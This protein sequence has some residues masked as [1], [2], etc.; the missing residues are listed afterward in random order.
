MPTSQ[1]G[2]S[3]VNESTTSPE[4]FAELQIRCDIGTAQ[5]KTQ[6]AGKGVFIGSTWLLLQDHDCRRTTSSANVHIRIAFS[7]SAAVVSSVSSFLVLSN[8]PCNGQPRPGKV[9]WSS[10]CTLGC[11]PPEDPEEPHQKEHNDQNLAAMGSQQA[12]HNR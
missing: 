10:S 1:Q 6:H 8:P 2:F 3:S 4:L 11:A 9:L 5:G 12:C 7:V